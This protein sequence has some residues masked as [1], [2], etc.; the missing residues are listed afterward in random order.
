MPFVVKVSFWLR[1]C[2]AKFFVVKVYSPRLRV[3]PV[4]AAALFCRGTTTNAGLTTKSTK[5]TKDKSFWLFFIK[6]FENFH[7]ILDLCNT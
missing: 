2:R 3:R 6:K 1:L 7:I 4:F 5:S